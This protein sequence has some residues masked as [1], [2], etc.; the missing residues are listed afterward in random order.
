MRKRVSAITNYP[1]ANAI[2]IITTTTNKDKN[3]FHDIHT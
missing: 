2:I 1:Q 3:I